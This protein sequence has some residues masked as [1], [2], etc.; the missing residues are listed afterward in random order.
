MKLQNRKHR[1]KKYLLDD[2]I[3]CVLVVVQHDYNFDKEPVKQRPLDVDTYRFVHMINLVAR[4][5]A[6]FQSVYSIDVSDD[7]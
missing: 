2:L 6:N 7:I 3:H 1:E 4:F 5:L